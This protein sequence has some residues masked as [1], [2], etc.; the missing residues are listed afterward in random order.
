MIDTFVVTNYSGGSGG[1]DASN[2]NMHACGGASGAGSA[3]FV[4]H[5][6]VPSLRAIYPDKIKCS[7]C[8]GKRGKDRYGNCEGCG[9]PL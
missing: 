8:G 6:T 5:T 4:V 1:S 3:V 2:I 7:Y 9:A